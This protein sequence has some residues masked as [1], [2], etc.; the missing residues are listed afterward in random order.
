VSRAERGLTGHQP[1]GPASASTP[2]ALD[3]RIVA[4]AT[5]AWTIY[6]DQRE[7]TPEPPHGVVTRQLRA[8]LRR[9]G[10]TGRHDTGRIA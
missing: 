9:H 2:V 4:I 5:L 1:G 7:K 10:D 3:S 8:G 6:C